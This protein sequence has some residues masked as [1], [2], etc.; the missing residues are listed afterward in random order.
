MG[1]K[2]HL[3]DGESI[4]R[5]FTGTTQRGSRRS[6]QQPRGLSGLELAPLAATQMRRQPDGPEAHA[7]QAAHGDS[8]GLEHSPDLAVAPF[9]QHDL[10]PAVRSAA[11]ARGDAV[12][13]G[14]AVFENDPLSESAQLLARELAPH[15]HRVLALD[16]VA[17]V[18][19]P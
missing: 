4:A 5:N 8:K 7:H 9:A 15:P 14:R 13:S 1:S 10:V 19:E 12:E 6:L 18:H 17:R 11:S 3:K 2:A 16:L